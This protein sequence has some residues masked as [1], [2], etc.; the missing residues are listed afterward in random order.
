MKEIRKRHIF[1]TGEK[2]VGKSTI[3]RRFLEAAGL[4]PE[5]LGGFQ[6][7]IRPENDGTAGIY[8]V[9]PKGS[10]ELNPENRILIRPPI[11]DGPRRFPE[12]FPEVLLEMFLKKV[13]S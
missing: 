10:E 3:I 5:E 9:S 13:P 2:Q 1:L 6:S 4:Q 7:A 8:L 12:V 11:S